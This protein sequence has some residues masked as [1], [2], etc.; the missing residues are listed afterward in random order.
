MRLLIA[1]LALATPAS[2]CAQQTTVV[3]R[4]LGDASV[5]ASGAGQTAF[6]HVPNGT[7]IGAA[8]RGLDLRARID[9][10]T[11]LS[12][13]TLAYTTMPYQRGIGLNFFERAYARGAATDVCGTSSSPARS[14]AQLGPHSLLL[15]F[16]N[17]PGTR[18]KVVFSF[19]ANPGT[20]GT[21]GAGIDIDND[22]AYELQAT[23]GAFQEFPY[24]IPQSGVVDVRVDNECH[25]TGTGNTADF[26]SC[27]TEIWVGFRPDLTAT[28]TISSYG[29]GCGPQASATDAVIGNNRVVTF[30]VTGAFANDPV[31]AIT[32]SHAIALQ[33]PGGC[34]LLSALDVATLVTADAQG[35]ATH[36]Y[37]IPA[38]LTGTTFN[39]FVPVQLQGRNLAIR[40]S[41]GVRVDCR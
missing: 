9:Q 29:Q 14:G 11:Y 4:T 33:L 3:V 2:L 7:A 35:I 38:T 40:T 28:C 31:V 27:W 39:Q 32:G 6:D 19:R 12:A 25:V 41:N 20:T 37:V 26:Q 5:Y 22:G 34:S 18:G 17:A 13:T 10:G 23:A 30:L 36:S 16:G 24:T 15:T 21:V 8:T 1:A